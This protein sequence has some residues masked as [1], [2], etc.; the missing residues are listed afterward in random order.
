MPPAWSDWSWVTTAAASSPTPAAPSFAASRS[1]GGPPSTRIG[2]G[3][4]GL[5]EDRVALADVEDRDPQPGR[6]AASGPASGGVA[7]EDGADRESAAATSD[8]GDRGRQGRAAPGEDG[9]GRDRRVGDDQP[10][11]PR[12]TSTLAQPGR[13]HQ[14]ATWAM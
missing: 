2:G 7:G 1:P 6:R 5:E 13:A 12:P 8:D 10:P 9:G 14:A 4:G 11:G 3:R